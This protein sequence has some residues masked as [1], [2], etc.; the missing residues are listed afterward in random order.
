[1]AI[2]FGEAIPIAIVGLGVNV[3]SAWLLSGSEHH[4]H[5]DAGHHGHEHPSHAHDHSPDHNHSHDSH[6]SPAAPASATVRDNSIRSAY[7]HVLADA[8]VSVLAIIGLVLARAYGWL[9]MDPVAGT[10]G[11]LVIANW[12]Y[13]L[14]RDTGCILLDVC[15]D[16]ATRDKLRQTIEEDG[17]RVVDLHLWRLGPGHLAAVV[18]VITSRGRDAS[19]YRAV[20]GRFKSLSHVTVEVTNV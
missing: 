6:P 5:G 20:L 7:V 13:G 3:V 15:P 2:H 12:S 1:V 9:W 18:A 8:A 14:L 17:D 19:Y 11:A 10:I 4:H 16:Q